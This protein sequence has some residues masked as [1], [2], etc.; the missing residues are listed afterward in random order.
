MSQV[1]SIIFTKPQ[2]NQTKA[3]TWLRKHKFAKLD[4]DIKPHTLRYRQIP[5]SKFKRFRIIEVEP[6]VHFVIGFA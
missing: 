6:T 2:W 5:P 3:K 1:Q 4:A